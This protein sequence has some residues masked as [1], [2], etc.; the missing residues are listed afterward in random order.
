[1]KRRMVRYRV[2][3]DRAAENI[4]LVSAIDDELLRPLVPPKHAKE[5]E[6]YE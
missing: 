6:D 1:V 5:E 3:P 2:K 4:E